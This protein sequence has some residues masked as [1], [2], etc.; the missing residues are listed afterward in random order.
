[1]REKRE[2]QKNL[3]PRI[4]YSVAE[5][6]DEWGIAESY[7]W[8]QIEAGRLKPIFRDNGKFSEFPSQRHATGAADQVGVDGGTFSFADAVGIEKAPDGKL[9]LILGE[10]Q[11]V[12]RSNVYIRHDDK[13][14]FERAAVVEAAASDAVSD[15][16]RQTLLRQIGAL[17]LV[18]AER[19]GKYRRG[20][21]PI[22]SQIAESA[23]ELAENL[24]EPILRG[25][26][27][28]SLR[29]HIQ[30]GLKPLQRERG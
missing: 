26:S 9:R 3:P 10:V 27:T 5:L 20:D 8:Q 1:M 13:M 23:R 6:A 2:S 15:A 28:K 21:A 22:A 17:A 29:T 18:I 25:L 4:R 19:K 7:V 14:L 11:T 30:A 16:E 12:A 24:P